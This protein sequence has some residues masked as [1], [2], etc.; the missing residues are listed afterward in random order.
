MYHKNAKNMGSLPPKEL[1]TPLLLAILA[2]RSLTIS[3]IWS[4]VDPGRRVGEW[5]GYCACVWT[6]LLREGE[7]GLLTAGQVH[8]VAGLGHQ[9][10]HILGCL[11]S[12]QLNQAL[13]RL[14]EG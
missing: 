14:G 10:R 6:S 7:E 9:G 8:H 13:S 3:E 11:D 5:G 2:P 1:S 4:Q 12:S